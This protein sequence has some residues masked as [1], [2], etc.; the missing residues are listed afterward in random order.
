MHSLLILIALRITPGLKLHPSNF[1]LNHKMSSL[2]QFVKIP[3]HISHI[4]VVN[5]LIIFTPSST[6]HMPLPRTM[7]PRRL[8]LK[9]LLNLHKSPTLRLMHVENPNKNGNNATPPKQEIGPEATLRKENGRGQR[10]G[11]VEHPVTRMGQ[12]GRRRSRALRL[13]LRRVYLDRYAPGHG[14]QRGEEIDGHDHDPATRAALLVHGVSGVQGAHHE[15]QDP[16][17]ESAVY[18]AR[19]PAPFVGVEEAR[20]RDCEDDER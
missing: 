14:I 16:H 17:P 18:N 9:S 11:K 1:Y 2:Q 3:K 8:P 7:S 19:S 20:D 5:K 15:H 13:D 6:A 10:H 12:R 4:R